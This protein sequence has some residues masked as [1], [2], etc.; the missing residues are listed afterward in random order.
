[1]QTDLNLTAY[2]RDK[3]YEWNY[4]NVPDP[5][6]MEIPDVPGEWEFCGLPLNSPL[7]IPAGPLL[8]GRWVLYYASLGFDMLT[9]KTVRSVYRECY[10]LPNLV[11]VVNKPLSGSERDISVNETMQGSWA[12]SY[13]MPSMEPDD[14]RAD[15]AWTRKHLPKHSILSVS[16]VGTMQE[17]W[18]LD[19]LADDYA[20][21]ASWA[22]ES[23]AD[24]VETNLS[25]PNVSSRDGQLYQ[26]PQSAKIVV[27]RV[28]DAIGSVPYILKI[29]HIDSLAEAEKLVAVLAPFVDAIAMPNCLQA[30]VADD[31]GKH[32]FDGQLRGIGGNAIRDASIAQIQLFHNC[33]RRDKLPLQLIGVGGITTAGDV[34]KYLAAGAQ[35]VH[36]ATAAM[37]DPAVGIRIRKELAEFKR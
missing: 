29:G 8:N 30:R 27:Q 26:Q 22:V 16:V 12:I 11:P 18:S 19:D 7:G 31:T 33:I 6:E 15:V 25:C 36:V 35:A 1:M 34:H 24:C 23:G 9:Y 21:C 10:R 32:L 4:H 5:V 37:V 2:D 28:R 13:G 20:R 3:T 17:G 14:W